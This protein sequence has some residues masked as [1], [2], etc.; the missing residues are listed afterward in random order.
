MPRKRKDPKEVSETRRA[1]AA[2]R[3][4][5]TKQE[6]KQKPL[7]ERLREMRERE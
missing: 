4:A 1:A 6:S 5:A 2:K 3:W 7:S